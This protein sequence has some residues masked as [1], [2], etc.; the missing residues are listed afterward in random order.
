MTHDQVP[1]DQFRDRSKG[2]YDRGQWL[3][4][5][6]RRQHVAA[7]V[8]LRNQ[9]HQQP[10]SRE[11]AAASIRRGESLESNLSGEGMKVLLPPL[12]GSKSFY[13]NRDLRAD[14]RSY[15]LSPLRG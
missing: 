8:S 15:M 14:A 12:R 2:V 6:K 11:A 10:Q 4:A 13:W 7:G 5:A 3:I 1:F 9:A